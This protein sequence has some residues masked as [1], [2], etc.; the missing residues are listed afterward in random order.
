MIIRLSPRVPLSVYCKTW[1]LVRAKLVSL[2]NF[3][4]PRSISSVTELLPGIARFLSKRFH[5]LRRDGS[6]VLRLLLVG[7]R[8]ISPQNSSQA[9]KNS[10]PAKDWKRKADHSPH[11]NQRESGCHWFA[12]VSGQGFSIRRPFAL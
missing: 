1:R 4:H 12:Q 5:R 3:N 7:T 10:S 2:V 6:S 11:H 8:E 9:A